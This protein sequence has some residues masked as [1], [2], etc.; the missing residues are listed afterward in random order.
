MAT[1]RRE[2]EGGDGDG[3]GEGEG[4]QKATRW[5]A[6]GDRGEVGERVEGEENREKLIYT[7]YTGN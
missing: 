1:A 6:I 7:A 4:G 3:D 2:R 5:M